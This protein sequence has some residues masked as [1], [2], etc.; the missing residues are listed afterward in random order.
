MSTSDDDCLDPFEAHFQRHSLDDA[1]VR[2]VVISDGDS[3]RSAL[4][5]SS[6]SDLL[7]AR[8][9]SAEVVVVV[10][11]EGGLAEA[12]E[13]GLLGASAPLVLITDAIAPWSS[14]HLDPLLK[15][16]NHCDHVFGRRA[17]GWRGAVGRWFAGLLWR[18]VFA[19]PVADVHSPCQLHRLAKLAAVPL[20]SGSKFLDVELL[21]KV[22]FLGHL[23][24]EVDVPDLATPTSRV[25]WG[26]VARVFKHPTFVRRPDSQSGRPAE[27]PESDQERDD[28]P[29]GEDR[30]GRGDVEQAG[31]FENHGAE[32][33]D[34]LGEREGVDDRLRGVGEPIRR[35]KDA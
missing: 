14:G 1:A 24:D 18:S 25:A 15:A 26:D 32:A 2:V 21:A 20:Q 6:I 4:V 10:V 34:E 16:I 7:L 17:I 13:G 9:R 31:P 11:D 8:G 5:G 30:Q 35:E 27:D 23:I 29:G 19:V 22:T 12:V 3:V 33:V 28:G